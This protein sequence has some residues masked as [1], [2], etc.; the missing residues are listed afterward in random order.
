MSGQDKQSREQRPPRHYLL[1]SGLVLAAFPTLDR[2][3]IDLK[4]SGQFSLS[5]PSCPA[6][7]H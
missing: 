6:G 1:S 3:R 5:E 4:F 2:A 7:G